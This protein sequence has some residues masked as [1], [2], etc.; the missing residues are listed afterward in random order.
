RSYGDG[1]SESVYGKALGSNRKRIFLTT[2]SVER[3]KAGAEADLDASLKAYQTDYVDL[4]QIHSIAKLEDLEEIF[5]PGGALEAFVAAKK[6]GKA[7]FIGFTGHHDPEVH[8]RMLERFDFDTILMPLHCADP[9]YLS[10]EKRVLARAAEKGMGIQAMKT[11]ANAKLLQ[12]LTVDQCMSYALTLPIHA[13]VLGCTT[14][15]QVD[16]AVRVAQAFQKLKP[17]QAEELVGRVKGIMGPDLEDWKR[18]T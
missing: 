12:S 18:R 6:A 7:R 8:A 16:D 3:T 13:A 2:K 4:W 5:A 15:G 1:F 11:L 10:F 17:S 14:P 9:H